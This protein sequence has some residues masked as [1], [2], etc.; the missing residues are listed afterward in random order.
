MTHIPLDY[1]QGEGMNYTFT[2]KLL[3]ECAS[4][5]LMHRHGAIYNENFS[6]CQDWGE[7]VQ[8]EGVNYECYT[9]HTSL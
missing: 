9:K 2:T 3:P 4:T 6:T 1:L 8:L 5:T 7:T